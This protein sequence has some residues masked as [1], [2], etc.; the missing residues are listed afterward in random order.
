VSHDLVADAYRFVARS[1]HPLARGSR[2]AYRALS[3]FSLPAPRL[4]VLPLLAAFIASRSALHFLWRVFVCEPLFKAYCTRHGR[5]LRTGVYV[6]WVQGKGDLRVGDDVL[7]DG[8]CS[9]TF[10]SRFSERPTL[11]IGDRTGIGHACSFT[12]GRGISIG[13]D[14]RI[15]GGVH[16]FDSSGHPADPGA[17]RQGLPPAPEDVRP[18]TI[19]DNVWIGRNA[20]IF[21]GVTVGLNSV[22]SAGAVVTADVPP[23]TVVAGNPARRVGS[24][25]KKGS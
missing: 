6:H 14:C 25:E 19:S 3:R 17:R 9:F 4:V 20:M 22:V 15:A 2:S 18:I 16:M 24:L 5:G 1:D 23:D 10:A 13:R 8:K 21:P 11:E 7:V 12:V